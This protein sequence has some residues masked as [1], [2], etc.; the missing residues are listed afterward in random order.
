MP[1]RPSRRHR[2]QLTAHARRHLA[3]AVL[4]VMVGNYYNATELHTDRALQGMQG[5]PRCVCDWAYND[6]HYGFE[7][8]SNAGHVKNK[9]CR[10]NSISHFQV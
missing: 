5:I 10:E 7:P 1:A 6:G 9:Y 4:T 3:Q 2:L 8:G